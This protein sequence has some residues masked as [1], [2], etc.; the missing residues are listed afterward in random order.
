MKNCP[1]TVPNISQ[2]DAGYIPNIFQTHPE[3]ILKTSE[4]HQN[5]IKKII[6]KSSYNHHKIIIKSS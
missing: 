4:N 1:K 2:N 3:N 6:I 5:I